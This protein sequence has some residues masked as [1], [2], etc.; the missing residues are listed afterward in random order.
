MRGIVKGRVE[1]AIGYG[2]EVD[3]QSLPCK[4][5]LLK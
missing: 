1:V 2:L 3:T 4:K 5:A